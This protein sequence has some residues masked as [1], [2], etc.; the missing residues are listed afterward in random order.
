LSLALRLYRGIA[1]IFALS[2]FSAF[3]VFSVDT[4]LV[5]L[6]YALRRCIGGFV[7]VIGLQSGVMI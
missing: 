5:A 1:P 6:S 4:V 3:S 7:L 2:V